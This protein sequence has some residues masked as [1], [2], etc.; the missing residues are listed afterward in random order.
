[1]TK[2]AIGYYA[3]GGIGNYIRSITRI[4]VESGKQV[5]ILTSGEVDASFKQYVKDHNGSILDVP[6]LTH[7]LSQYRSILK[8]LKS[9]NYDVAYFN[10]SEAFNGLGIRAA[11]EAGV[12]QIIVHSHASGCD[13]RNIVV[14]KC[15]ILLNKIGQFAFI[16]YANTFLSCSDKAS[17]WLFPQKIVKSGK[18]IFVPNSID[19]EKYSF[20][21]KIRSVV[22]SEFNLENKFVVGYAG[23]FQY[24]KNISYF[25]KVAKLLLD[26]N[27]VFLMIGDGEDKENLQ[28]KIHQ[29]DIQEKFIFTGYRKDVDRM[30]NAMD[31]FMLPS[32]Y[33]GLP[34]VAVEAQQNGLPVLLSD[35]ITH[36]VDVSHE[37]TYLPLS[38]SGVEWRDAILQ[39]VYD[40]RHGV[41]NSTVAENFGPDIMMKII[42]KIIK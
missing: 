29:Q 35:T 27:V 26:T 31:L 22:R 21:S 28:K 8:I 19:T 20:S 42:L 13:R 17:E 2:V 3:G 32:L 12:P 37:C 6:R 1:M 5:D 38:K 16:P 15:R 18:V 33:E 40:V 10:I 4:L 36:M 24:V 14:R 11:K 23:S 30:M 39:H 25:L 7:P 41:V 34:F 9:G